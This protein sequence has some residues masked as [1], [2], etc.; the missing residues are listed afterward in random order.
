MPGFFYLM[1]LGVTAAAVTWLATPL[2]SLLGRRMGA[3]DQPDEL[4]I[5]QT[6]TPRTGGIAIAVGLFIGAQAA[7]SQSVD[8]IANRLV[9]A[10]ATGSAMVFIVGLLDDL[11]E[12]KPYA[13]ALGLV[14][15]AVT[16]QLI[17]PHASVTGFERLDFIIGVFILMLGA[18]AVNLLDGMDGLASGL[19]VIM[20]LGFAAILFLDGRPLLTA[21]SLILS[22][23][24]LGFWA[25]NRPPARIFMGDCGSLMLGYILAGMALRTSTYGP[26]QML[27]AAA[28]LSLPILDTGLAMFRRLLAR[29]DVFSGDRKHVYDLLY[30]RHRSA[31]R[32]N[33]IM[34]LMAAAFAALGVF[35]LYMSWVTTLIVLLASWSCLAVWMAKLGMFSSGER[36]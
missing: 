27:A 12:I 32:V 34:Y 22:G 9:V 28:V 35:S 31:W 24:A 13:K 6:A 25:S 4:G 29:E 19:T 16:G 30:L 11:R 17:A 33:G 36:S 5:H 21:Q 18:N 20:G 7:W 26:N 10:A 8:I 2:A 23:A 3:W 14:A 15:A 1:M